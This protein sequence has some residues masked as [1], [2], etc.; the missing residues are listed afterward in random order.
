MSDTATLSDKVEAALRGGARVV[1][2]RNKSADE[3]L[4]YRQARA[5]SLLCRRAGACFVVNDSVPLARALDA[6]GVHLG[7][8]DESIASARRALGGGK[9]VGI[10][11]YNQLSLA[12]EAAASGADYVAF[13]SFFVSP[14][15]PEAIPADV[16]LLA[17]ARRQ[18]S[19][20]IVAIGGITA[21]NAAGLIESGADA[22]AVV[23]A[24]FDSGDVEQA[25]RRFSALFTLQ[26]S[27]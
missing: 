18:L 27:S 13:G 11:C 5:I 3:S 25:A 16:A 4:L 12:R 17:L 9:L 23:S 22:V 14:T 26:R 6:D 19:I 2:Y 7:S 15:K 21:D 8:G 10:S 24:L 1:Q 20:P